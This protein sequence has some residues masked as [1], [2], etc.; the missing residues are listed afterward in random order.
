SMDDS[1][2]VLSQWIW[3]RS[4][5]S[6]P[7]RKKCPNLTFLFPS[8]FATTHEPVANITKTY[9]RDLELDELRLTSTNVKKKDN[10]HL[11]YGYFTM[12]NK[13]IDSNWNWYG[14]FGWDFGAVPQVFF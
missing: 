9:T 13:A 5:R 4:N 3:C 1:Y 10:Y 6:R 12:G 7:R 11:S 8:Y 14:L 2:C